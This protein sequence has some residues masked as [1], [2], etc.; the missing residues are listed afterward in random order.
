MVGPIQQHGER[1]ASPVKDNPR[2]RSRSPKRDRGADV[3]RQVSVSVA[4]NGVASR[5]SPTLSL[6]PAKI[7][8]Q[9]RKVLGEDCGSLPVIVG[10]VCAQLASKQALDIQALSEQIVPHLPSEKQSQ[11]KDLLSWLEEVSEAAKSDQDQAPS[12]FQEGDA[13]TLHGLEKRPDLNGCTAEVLRV[14]DPSQPG[15]IVLKLESGSQIA[16]RPQNLQRVQREGSAPASEKPS[17][18]DEAPTPK[19][20]QPVISGS[21]SYSGPD[22]SASKVFGSAFERLKA[23]AEAEARGELPADRRKKAKTDLDTRGGIGS[24]QPAGQAR[25]EL[26]MGTEP[27][28][29]Q[30]EVAEEPPKREPINFVPAEEKTIMPSRKVTVI[31]PRRNQR[32]VEDSDDEEVGTPGVVRPRKSVQ[33]NGSSWQGGSTSFDSPKLKASK[34]PEPVCRMPAAPAR[35]LARTPSVPHSPTPTT[36]RSYSTPP[37]SARGNMTL[38]VSADAREA[39]KAQREL[40][41]KRKA[42]EEGKRH[43]LAKLTKQMQLCLAKLQNPDLDDNAK[44]K[45][46]DMITSLKT[47]MSKL[48]NV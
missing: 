4:G 16:I 12:N 24:S 5:S 32:P 28:E 8:E 27:K 1:S 26:I 13:V 18:R 30:T 44:E 29:S 39:D 23:K 48:G 7:T 21:S 46:Q 15:R 40:A 3:P 20:P 10:I 6:E 14:A 37:A 34:D 42:M 36:S 47:N 45:Y 43:M 41:E 35:G 17:D 2:E 11:L 33:D 31:D 22:P 9:V 25:R 19:K 38:V